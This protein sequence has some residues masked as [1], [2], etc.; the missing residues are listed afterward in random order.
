MPFLVSH[1]ANVKVQ[2]LGQYSISM[3]K[4]EVSP[5]PPHCGPPPICGSSL[6]EPGL[7]ECLCMHFCQNIAGMQ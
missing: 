3:R 4:K 5:P 7:A 2:P 1:T 6:N